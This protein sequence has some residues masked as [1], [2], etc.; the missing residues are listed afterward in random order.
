MLTKNNKGESRL[1]VASEY[2]FAETNTRTVRDSIVST[3]QSRP[4]DPSESQILGLIEQSGTLD[5]WC[6]DEEDE[7][8]HDDGEAIR[9]AGVHDLSSRFRGKPGR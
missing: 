6:R 7:Y 8:T 2:I 5:F 9:I 4:N 3:F 1:V